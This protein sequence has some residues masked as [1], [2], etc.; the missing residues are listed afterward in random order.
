M[1]LAGTKSKRHLMAALTELKPV[2]KV[3]PVTSFGGACCVHFG[4]IGLDGAQ[5]TFTQEVAQVKD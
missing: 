2:S 4:A 3:M 5:A 1:A